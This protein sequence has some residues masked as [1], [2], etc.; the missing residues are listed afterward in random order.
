MDAVAETFGSVSGV[1]FAVSAEAAASLTG[2]VF[3]AAALTGVVFAR[4][5]VAG[6]ILAVTGF[7]LDPSARSTSASSTVDT[8]LLMSRPA[9]CSRSSSS[10]LVSP[11]SL[12][13]S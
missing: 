7:A 1:T 2:M 10:W 8:L 12:A 13:M 6:A 4:S 5:A 9:A 11:F 3:V